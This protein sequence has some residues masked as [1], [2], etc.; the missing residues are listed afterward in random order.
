MSLVLIGIFSAGSTELRISIGTLFS[1]A[2]GLVAHRR[3]SLSPAF[4]R[5]HYRY[6]FLSFWLLA[7]TNAL[8]Y[9]NT[10]GRFF[11]LFFPRAYYDPETPGSGFTDWHEVF[12]RRHRDD[13][14]FAWHFLLFAF[15]C[16]L[17]FVCLPFVIAFGR[18]YAALDQRRPS[19]ERAFAHVEKTGEYP[20][21]LAKQ[22]VPVPEP[23]RDTRYMRLGDDI[24]FVCG[25]GGGFERVVTGD[26]DGAISRRRGISKEFA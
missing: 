24:I 6:I 3:L 4:L 18:W 10:I 15:W 13:I 21:W 20:P 1:W 19:L 17:S 22:Q 12:T 2:L 9:E 14:A 23:K 8:F 5:Y 25:L 11:D 26:Y 16:G 7:A